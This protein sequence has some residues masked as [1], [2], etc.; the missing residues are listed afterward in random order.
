MV[1]FAFIHQIIFVFLLSFYDFFF[2]F[3]FPFYFFCKKCL[4]AEKIFEI[5]GGH[6]REIFFFWI[7]KFLIFGLFYGKNHRKEKH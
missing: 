3:D 7:E 4:L 6:G 2:Q 1:G 5:F